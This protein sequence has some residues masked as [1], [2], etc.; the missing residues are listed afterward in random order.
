MNSFSFILDQWFQLNLMFYSDKAGAF[1]F[2]P[3][4]SAGKK[5]LKSRVVVAKLFSRTTVIPAV[6]SD[7]SLSK[8]QKI[9]MPYEWM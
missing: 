3:N 7:H 5:N 4:F 6:S 8:R 2:L 9:K 1:L